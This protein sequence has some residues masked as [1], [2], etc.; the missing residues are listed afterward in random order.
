MQGGAKPSSL[1]VDEEG[2]LDMSSDMELARALREG[3]E[4]AL[5]AIYDRYMPGI[6]D[7]LARFLRD[8][9]AAEDLAQMTFIRAWEKRD[10]LRDPARVKS[11]LYTIAHNLATNHVT[12][13]RRTQPIDEEFDLA[14]AAPGPEDQTAAK[15]VAELV[16]A[17]AASLEPR[18][19]GARALTVRREL[20]TGE[21]AQVL[22]IP[23]GHA[24]VL[25]NRAKEALGNAVRYL[26]VAQRRDHCQRLA[27]LV[28]AG[29]TSLTPEQRGSVDRHMRRCPEC[30]G[31]A[32]QLTMPAEL[33][34]GLVALPLPVSLRPHGRDFVLVGARRESEATPA[35]GIQL[36]TRPRVRPSRW[37]D[38]RRA[39]LA[40]TALLLLGI[41]GG[42]LYVHRPGGSQPNPG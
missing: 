16:W 28:P 5:A 29:V 11:W 10:S 26:L 36:G 25:V 15:A 33:F 13:N 9:S 1:T 35:G 4:A 42:E 18:Q 41:A 20:A 39:A 32:R 38:L 17:A 8:R 40:A 2:G 30:Q 23:A 27:E 6:Y 14:S 22:G 31:L 21:I 34:G 7:F 3:D 24:A 19:Y 37:T 12:R